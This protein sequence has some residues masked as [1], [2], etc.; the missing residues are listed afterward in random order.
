MQHEEELAFRAAKLG[1]HLA[2]R[3]RDS[4]LKQYDTICSIQKDMKPDEST[5]SSLDRSHEPTL[6]EST[7]SDKLPPPLHIT[8]GI[9]S[10]N[11]SSPKLNNR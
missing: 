6:P 11:M 4:L 2:V 1:F 9:N 7:T 10:L 5:E 8:A 3:E